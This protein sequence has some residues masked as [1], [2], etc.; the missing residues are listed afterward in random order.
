[1]FDII[2][3]VMDLKIALVCIAK[4]EDKY[5]E[6]WLLYNKKLGF[7]QIFLYQNDWRT[8]LEFDYLTKIEFDGKQKQLES[9]ADFL[10]KYGF[11]YDWAAFFDVDEFLVLKKHNNV[12]E[13]IGDYLKF[14]GVGINWVLFGDNNL[15][16]SNKE[17]SLLKRFTKRRKEPEAHVKSIVKIKKCPK[18][19]VHHPDCDI[20]NTNKN[21]FYGVFNYELLDN[22]AQINH[23]FCKTK[24][25]F[26]EKID[27]G[28]SDSKRIRKI[29]DFF[30]N[31]Y[32]EVEDLSA[33]N[34][35][36]D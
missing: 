2:Y 5:I 14:N 33:L 34:F 15:E 31:N 22:V 12:K 29:K 21:K 11:D 35:L 27:R 19:F 18:M 30:D 17:H 13:F 25:E 4:N 20:V 28:R 23:Y 26:L 16:H 24:K 8:N 10:K 36:Y 9:Y 6:E 3:N 32:N 7:D 1:M